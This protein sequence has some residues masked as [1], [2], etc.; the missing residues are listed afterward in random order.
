M[1]RTILCVSFDETVAASRRAA[2]EEAGYAVVT[3]TQI[4]E[5]LELLS[6]VGFDLIVVG[7]RFSTSDKHKLAAEARERGTSV[8]LI[9]GAAADTQIPA[10]SRVYAL[11]GSAGLVSAVGNLLP[12]SPA[13]AA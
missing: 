4:A 13:A 1:K 10:D 2:L 7:H 11:E 3:T 5:A 9:C 12:A 6:S 8:L